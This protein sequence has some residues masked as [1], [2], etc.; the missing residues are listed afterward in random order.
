MFLVTNGWDK[1][2][3]LIMVL[4]V[5]LSTAVDAY[6]IVF[7]HL[8]DELPSYLYDAGHQARL[9]NATADIMVIAEQ[10]AIDCYDK[11]AFIQDDIV[12]VACEDLKPSELHL[13]F[14]QKT[15]LDTSFRQ[16]FW[17]KCTERFYLI[18]ELMRQHE[19]TD[20]F[21]LEYDNMLYVDLDDIMDVFHMYPN[22]AATFD[23]DDRCIP[24]FMYFAHA[25]AATNLVTYI[26][27]VCTSGLNDMQVIARYKNWHGDK[28]ISSLPITMPAYIKKI[29]LRSPSGLTVVV[30]ESYASHFEDFN[31]IFDAAALGQYLGG[32]DPRNGPSKQGFINESCV[33]NPSRLKF[34]WTVDEEGRKVPF[35]IFEEKRYR[36]NNLHIHSKNLKEFAS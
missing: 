9:F 25:Q 4:L 1:L 30:P 2:Y 19:L 17:R 34:E 18:E 8:G 22:S 15:L 24:G 6:S 10:K 29:G 14:R 16:G 23:N 5:L 28:E 7:V 35:A 3:K 13:E 12:F 21:H 32:I 27:S 31:S 20:V 26:T 36:I 33:F 11:E